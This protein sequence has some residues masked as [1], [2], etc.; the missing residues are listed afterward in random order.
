MKIDL[1]KIL[2]EKA[3]KL[4][5]FTAKIL[6]SY[7]KRIVHQ[8][9]LNAFLEKNH[10]LPPVEFARATLNNLEITYTVHGLDEID[11]SKRYLFASNHPF[12]GLDGVMLAVIL[13]DKFSDVKVIVNDI[14]MNLVPVAPLFVPINKHGKQNTKYANDYKTAMSSSL[15]MLTFPAGLCSR[16]NKGVITDSV[17]KPSFIK[18]AVEFQ[19]DIVPVFCEGKLSNFFYNLHSFRTKFGIKANLEMLYLA[20]EMFKQKGQHFNIYFGEVIPYKQIEE[21]GTAREWCQK[22]REISYNLKKQD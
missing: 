20:D 8:K 18:H 4:S 16:R 12:G 6:A 10:H 15:P 2:K 11:T 7:L 21:G 9:E 19:R 5:R 1:D 13:N 3:P 22:I 17:W 14:L